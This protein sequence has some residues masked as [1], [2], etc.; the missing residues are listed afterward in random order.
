MALFVARAVWSLPLF[1]ALAWFARPDRRPPREDWLLL[2]ATGI[3]F[4]PGACGFLALAAQYTSGAH[5]VML[6]SLGAPLTAVMSAVVLKERVDLLRIVAL[7]IGIAGAILLSLARS[8]SGSSI[9][10]D[11]FELVQ[12]VAFSA[13]FVFTRGLGARYSPFFVSGTYGSIGMAILVLVGILSGR[14]V[15]SAVLP[16]ATGPATLWWFFGE[17]VI[18]LSI[19]GQTAQA[20]ALRTLGAGITSLLSSYGTLIVGLIGAVWLLG[21]RLSPVGFVA[22]AMLA[23]AL[24][25][26]LVPRAAP[27]R[28]EAVV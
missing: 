14:L 15:S 4:G 28:G 17:I 2:I 6:L 19:Y 22:C 5:V 23:T 27:A 26:A 25:L 21:E 1:L 20:F 13:M 3:C 7:A 8:A 24:G 16:F 9:A 11:L 10:G 18:G 12:V